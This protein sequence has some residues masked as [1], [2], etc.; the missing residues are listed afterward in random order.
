[1]NKKIAQLASFL[2][3]AIVAAAIGMGVSLMYLAKPFQKWQVE[4]S[5]TYLPI[6]AEA[7][8]ELR[9]GK[10]DKATRYLEMASTFSL[11]AMGEQR[12]EGARAPTAQQ[13]V[14]AIKYLCGQ[15]P[16]AASRNT[17]SKLTFA[18]SCALLLKQ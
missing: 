11:V 8:R 7:L 13:T 18:E 5:E 10:P 15:P 14:E 4:F 6:Q 12:D 2:I 17:S 1:M 16:T 9:E 3:V